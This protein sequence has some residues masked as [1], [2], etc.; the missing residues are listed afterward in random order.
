M[1]RIFYSLNEGA[2]VIHGLDVSNADDVGN[3]FI[4]SAS[5]AV[6][7]SAWKYRGFIFSIIIII[8]PRKLAKQKC[9]EMEKILSLV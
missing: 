8:L 1:K 6:K 2:W 4:I 9:T 3:G 7:L 5:K